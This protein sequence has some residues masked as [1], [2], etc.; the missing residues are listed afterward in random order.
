MPS[1]EI[2]SPC[3]RNCCLDENDVCLGCYRTIGEIIAWGEASDAKKQ[4][5]LA[6]AEQRRARRLEA[7]DK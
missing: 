4:E 5:I 7:P 2:A 3:V 6:R 1:D